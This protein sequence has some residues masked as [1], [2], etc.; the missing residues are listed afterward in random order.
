MDV[1][2]NQPAMAV[3][4]VVGQPVTTLV[5][6]VGTVLLTVIFLAVA[7]WRFRQEDF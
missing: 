6:I 4:L 7:L 5:P 1:G 3:Q 2:P